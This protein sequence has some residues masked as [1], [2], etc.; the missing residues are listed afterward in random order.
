ME[1]M[2]L[3]PGKVSPISGISGFDAARFGLDSAIT[4]RRL[5]F[6]KG[7]DEY[8]MS[9]SSGTRP[10]ITSCCAGALPL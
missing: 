5:S 7:M 1:L 2:A 3:K 9:N 6:T 8:R 10:P 4:F